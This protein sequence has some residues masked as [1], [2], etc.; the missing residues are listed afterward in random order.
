MQ[1]QLDYV[2][3]QAQFFL[4]SSHFCQTVRFYVL[5]PLALNSLIIQQPFF[6]TLVEKFQAP[7]VFSPGF[8]K[9]NNDLRYT[10]L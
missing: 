7:S 4:Y 9:E 3:A 6:L 8:Q 2:N 10:V 5:I 1:E